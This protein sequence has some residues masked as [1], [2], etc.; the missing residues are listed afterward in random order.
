MHG[1]LTT[2][3]ILLPFVRPDAG[4]AHNFGDQLA[5]AVLQHFGGAIKNLAA[6]VSCGLAPAIHRRT[7]G[8]H[9]IAEILA[10]GVS[11]IVEVLALR[12][13]RRQVTSAFAAWKLSASEEL[14]GFFDVEACAHVVSFLKFIL[15]NNSNPLAKTQ[16]LDAV[17]QFADDFR[18]MLSCTSSRE[19]AGGGN[20]PVE[21]S[22]NISMPTGENV[23]TQISQRDVCELILIVYRLIVFGF[24]LS[25]RV[26]GK[27]KPAQDIWFSRSQTPR[28]AGLVTRPTCRSC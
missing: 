19:P 10:G 4:R 22:L 28:S 2:L 21:L 20:K 12:R 25:W 1:L 24:L 18:E 6:I 17:T 15:K 23:S 7:R 27:Q 16:R 14:V 5:R 26:A 3:K 9:G 13:F 11:E 8:D